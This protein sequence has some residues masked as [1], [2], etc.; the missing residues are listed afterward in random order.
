MKEEDSEKS[1]KQRKNYD[2]EEQSVKTKKKHKVTM[3]L[4]TVANAY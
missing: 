1:K 2:K 3:T 4:N